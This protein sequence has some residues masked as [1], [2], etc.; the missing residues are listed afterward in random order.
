MDSGGKPN[1]DGAKLNALLADKNQVTLDSSGNVPF[2]KAARFSGRPGAYLD[3]PYING[4]HDHSFTIAVWVNLSTNDRSY[5]LA[6]WAEPKL[7]FAFGFDPGKNVLAPHLSVMMR[8]DVVKEV[9]GKKTNPSIVNFRNDT[10]VGLNTWHHVAWTWDRSDEKHG[11]LSAYLDG[12]KV[13]TAGQAARVMTVNIMDNR[14]P[15]KI[16]FKQDTE[17]TFHGAMDELWIFDTALTDAQVMNLMKT[18]DIAT[19][20]VAAAPAA[21]APTS[22]PVVTPA[23][24]VAV[25]TASANAT[26]AAPQSIAPVAAPTTPESSTPA[27]AVV[28]AVPDNKTGSTFLT[29]ATPAAQA[30]GTNDTS[31]APTDDTSPPAASA[32]VAAEAPSEPATP[33]FLHAAPTR[34][35]SA[36]TTVLPTLSTVRPAH[37]YTPGRLLGIFTSGLTAIALSG[38]L[39]WAKSERERM[40]HARR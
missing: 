8:N 16:G 2:G 9:R 5:V 31:A 32:P 1:S 18:N 15:M 11:T 33:D 17:S 4:I 39:F 26:P 3:L 10:M 40:R 19:V 24:P 14:H 13:A 6:D 29:A 27:P 35:G 21:V 37:R 7:S 36:P 38:F 23:A 22:P 30:S 25:P 12:V 20:Q 34:N 28:I